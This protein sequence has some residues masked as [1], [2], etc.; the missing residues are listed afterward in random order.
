[1]EKKILVIN[2]GSSSLKFQLFEMPQEKVLAQGLVE[3]IGLDISAIHYKTDGD[4]I[5]KELEIPNHEE[6]LR[7]VTELLLDEKI[8]VIK[9]VEEIEIVAHRVVHGRKEFTETV[10]INA[11]VKD[12]IRSL[13]PLAPLH[14]PANLKG[15][16]V[17]E[18]LFTKAEQVAVFDTSFFK[19]LPE[20]AYRYAI[21]KDKADEND[22][23]VY[24]FHGIS[25]KYV[26]GKAYEFLN[27]SDKKQ[28]LI[29]I[30]L[31]NGCS[32]SAVKDGKAIDHSL[33][34]GPND[35]L[36]MGTRCGDI[37]SSVVFTLMNKYGYSA[38]EMSNLL[39]KQSGML[40][41]TG[42]SDM[43]DIEGAA[44]EGNKECQLALEMN[45]YRIKKYIGAYIAAMDGVDA[46][47]FT[48]GIGENSDIIRA[49]ATKDLDYFGIKIDEEKNSIRTKEVRD[50]SASDSKVK[51]IVVPT[52]EELEIAQEAYNLK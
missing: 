33:G 28:K 13:F 46:L 40:G 9:N 25:H 21:P 31:G 29:T 34:F 52:N 24:G 18:K 39:S 4:K 8:G 17:A 32:M 2:S 1:M 49:M 6:A 20:H 37:D 16:E 12:K 26:S 30:H 48:A 22:I 11:L 27:D 51:I 14:N 47:V 23:R 5:S 15:I 7:N 44:A 41:L 36:I 43:R 10:K 42:M 45:T 38:D 50:V 3:R 19:T 35:G